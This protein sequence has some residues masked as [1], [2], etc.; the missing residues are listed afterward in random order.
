REPHLHP[1]RHLYSG[2]RGDVTYNVH[3][4]KCANDGKTCSPC[5]NSVH[6]VPRQFGLSIPKVLIT[7]LLSNTNYTFSIEAVNGVSDLSPTPK[8]EV[9]VNIT[10]G[11]TGIV[12]FLR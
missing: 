6:F 7:D 2:G 10:T 1:E 3:C 12:S 4:K 8:Q 5:S 9:T 11:Q